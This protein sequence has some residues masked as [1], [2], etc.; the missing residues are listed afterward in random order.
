MKSKTHPPRPR[1]AMRVGVT[2]HREVDQSRTGEIVGELDAVF[3]VL[4]GTIEKLAHS[5]AAY[6]DPR[7][8]LKRLISPLAEGADSLAADAAR[9][10]GFAIQAPI[11]FAAE[12]YRKDF[13]GD[14]ATAFERQLDSANAVFELDGRRDDSDRVRQL[15]YLAAGYLTLRQ[16]DVLIAIW[17][18]QAA[19]GIGG[20]AMIVEAA[21]QRGI[22]VIWIH[23]EK[24]AHPCLMRVDLLPGAPFEEIGPILLQILA[25]PFVPAGSRAQDHLSRKSQHSADEFLR[26]VE[27]RLNFGILFQLFQGVMTLRRPRSIGLR[28]RSFIKAAEQDWATF[29]KVVSEQRRD[30]WERI[31]TALAPRFAWADG[32]A[33]FYAGIYRSSYILNYALSALAVMLA[34]SELIIHVDKTVCNTLEIVTIVAIL[35]ITTTGKRKRW[36]E[37]WIDYR[38][39]AEQLRHLRFLFLTGG[40]PPSMSARHSYDSGSSEGGWVQ[41]YYMA[42]LRELGLAPVRATAQYLHKIKTLFLKEEIDRQIRYHSANAQRMHVIDHTLHKLGD[43]TFGC[44]LFVCVA[45]VAYS[46]LAGLLDGPTPGP[47]LQS[48]VTFVSAFFPALGAAMSGVRVQGEFSSIAERSE[49][50][51]SRLRQL[52]EDLLSTERAEKTGIAGL[53]SFIETTSQTMLTDVVDWRFVF[54]SK[55]LSLPA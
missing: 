3:T 26:E 55:P 43:A 50:M 47:A 44:A 20:T 32:L 16:C 53:R 34:L 18:G 49:A 19:R 12:D 36:H 23:A 29:G 40:T 1:L 35:W 24:A 10:H 45:F 46:G 52:Q 4:D 15:S 39:L 38:Q 5:Y 51:A 21:V 17:D 13:S 33:T 7:A 25:P 37:R 9:S 14:S 2:G 48:W 54:R 27:R 31:D 6:F 42:T 8:P 22:P 30:A 28:H 41:W 11:P